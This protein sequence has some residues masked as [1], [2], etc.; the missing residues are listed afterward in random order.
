MKYIP[1]DTLIA[2][3]ERRKKQDVTFR[4]R[5]ILIDIETAITSLQQE[6]PSRDYDEAYLNECIAKAS[7]T[8]KGVDADKYLD[9]VR[10]REQEQPEVDLEKEIKRY[11]EHY[12]LVR[13]IGFSLGWMDIETTARHFFELGLKARGNDCTIV[14]NCKMMTTDELLKILPSAIGNHKEGEFYILSKPT[15]QYEGL[16][17]HNDGKD[18]LASYGVKGEF[19]CMNPEAP[20]ENGFYNNAF[21]YGKTPNEALQGLY[22]WCVKNGFIERK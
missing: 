6:Q 12:I 4:E 14:H 5:S 18:W 17:L 2:E 3:I 22:N 1:V 10:G 16:Y 21:A 13:D 11:Q 9:E 8:W 20:D 15:D 19:V 7:K